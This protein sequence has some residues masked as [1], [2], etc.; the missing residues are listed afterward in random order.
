MREV[1]VDATTSTSGSRLA[2]VGSCLVQLCNLVEGERFK[3]ISLTVEL[4]AALDYQGT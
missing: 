3:L 2:G 4:P 1:G